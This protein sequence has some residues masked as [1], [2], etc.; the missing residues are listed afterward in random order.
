MF[1]D[2]EIDGLFPE[3]EPKE[4]DYAKLSKL[5]KLTR[6]KVKNYRDEDSEYTDKELP[7]VREISSFLTRRGYELRGRKL[8]NTR[9]GLEVGSL[10]SKKNLTAACKDDLITIKFDKQGKIEDYIVREKGSYFNQEAFNE[11]IDSE[12]DNDVRCSYCWGLKEKNKRTGKMEC[13]GCTNP[14]GD[15]DK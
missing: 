13:Y 11:E 4:I 10:D 8:F 9:K 3:E 14:I 6:N 5:S 12:I 1:D 2:L 15:R 7:I